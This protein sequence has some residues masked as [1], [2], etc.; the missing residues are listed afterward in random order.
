MKFRIKTTALVLTCTVLLVGLFSCQKESV[1]IE[2]PAIV[3]PDTITTL[4]LI[5]H[6]ETFGSAS[7]PNLST[8]GETRANELVTELENITLDVV[9]STIFKRTNQTASP[10]AKDRSLTIENYDHTELEA[11]VDS[12]MAIY[13]GE[14]V[15]VVGHS[16][17]TPDILNILL[18]STV[19]SDIPETEY[20]N[21]YTFSVD[22]YGKTDVVHQKYGK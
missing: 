10:I 19:Y 4:I 7:N 22:Q 3:I 2:T 13:R 20:D 11:F 17:T 6:A 9:F 15:L 5:R 12:T 8:A 18:D 16:G 1:S 21:M 14:T